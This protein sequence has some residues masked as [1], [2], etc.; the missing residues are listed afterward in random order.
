MTKEEILAME[1]GRELDIMIAK[2]LYSADTITKASRLSDRTFYALVGGEK[3][4]YQPLEKGKTLANVWWRHT[5]DEA[6]DACPN[7]STDISAAWEVVAKIQDCLHLREHGE[8]GEWEASFCGLDAKGHGETAQL[9][10]CK[11]ALL[12]LTEENT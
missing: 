7:Y 3:E 4:R 10:I 11:A 5:A 9:A 8:Q 1:A 12:T 6:W 2:K